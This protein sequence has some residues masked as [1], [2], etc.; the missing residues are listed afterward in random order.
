MYLK[1]GQISVMENPKG[2]Y[3]NNIKI[4]YIACLKHLHNFKVLKKK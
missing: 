4:I 1:K 2:N 3:K